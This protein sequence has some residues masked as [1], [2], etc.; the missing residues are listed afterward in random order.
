MKNRKKSH[1]IGYVKYTKNSL[2]RVGDIV[3]YGNPPRLSKCVVHDI[4]PN[5]RVQVGWRTW[6]VDYVV[7]RVD[8]YRRAG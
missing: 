6:A 2:L 3:Y 4:K 1:N 8:L 7:S 5:G